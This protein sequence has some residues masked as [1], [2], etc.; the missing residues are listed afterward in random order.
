MKTIS[1]GFMLLVLLVACNKD[2]NP[3][4]EDA[5][6]TY[7]GNF[8]SITYDAGLIVVTVSS[9]GAV[10]GTVVMWEDTLTSVTVSGTINGNTFT[11]TAS[12][13]TPLSGTL[14]NG[15]IT[16]TAGTES[17]FTIRLASGSV[18]RLKYVGSYV[19]T[20]GPSES[21]TLIIHTAATTM[22]GVILDDATP[23]QVSHLVG[24]VTG[25]TISAR[26]A[27][28]PSSEVAAGTLSGSTWSGTYIGDQSSGTWTVTLVP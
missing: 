19:S 15:V 18:Q 21:G 23:G 7:V 12:D 24:T 11:G 8:I 13:G 6:G 4:G 1:I 5:V 22:W 3:V 14:S 20:S 25:T 10:S 16:G 17:T 9:S 26:E 28:D 27:S 2:E